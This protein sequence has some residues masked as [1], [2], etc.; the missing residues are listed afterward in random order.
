MQIYYKNKKI[1]CYLVYKTDNE[2]LKNI[3]VA[4]WKIV[5]GLRHL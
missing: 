2:Q 4:A 1:G 3:K 5:Q